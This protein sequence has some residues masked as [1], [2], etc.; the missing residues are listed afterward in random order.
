MG[1]CVVS[2]GWLRIPPAPFTVAIPQTRAKPLIPPIPLAPLPPVLTRRL[3]RRIRLDDKEHKATEIKEAFVDFKREIL[4]GAENSRTA[5][6]IPPKLIKQFEESEE[7]KDV[8]VRRRGVVGVG[9]MRR[10]VC[11]GVTCSR[12]VRAGEAMAEETCERALSFVALVVVVAAPAA[13]GTPYHPVYLL[14]PTHTPPDPSP[15]THHLT[16]AHPHTT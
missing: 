12:R 4:K 6:P 2:I 3:L 14:H 13:L 5:K 9:Y 16:L 7:M 11:C 8:D 10:G 1:V 15:P